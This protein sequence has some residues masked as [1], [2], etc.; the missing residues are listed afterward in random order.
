MRGT[1]IASP[2][3][4]HHRHRQLPAARLADRPREAAQLAPA[5]GP[6]GS[7]GASRSPTSPRPRTTRPRSRSPTR[8][9]PAS[10]RHR[11][12]DPAREL[13]QP[14]R[15]RARG[16]RHRQ[17]GAGPRPRGR[18][19]RVP[20]IVGKVRRTRPVEVDD[21]ASC[22]P[23]RPHRQDHPARPVH[24]EPAGPTSPTTTR[25][26]WRWTSRSPSTRRSATCSRR[27]PTRPDRRAVA[28]VAGRTR[29]RVR[30]PRH[31]PRAR[32]RTGTTAL[33][34]CFGYA[35]VVPTGRPATRSWPSSPT[36][37]PTCSRSR[38][39]SRSSTAVLERIA[40]KTVIVGVL[41]LQR[42]GRDARAGR[43]TASRRRSPC[44]RGRLQ[45]APT[46]G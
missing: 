37:P 5:A 20:R 41:D 39:P 36:A 22:A 45:S 29:P 42:G 26:S 4:A 31:R 19:E 11:R 27:A 38:P 15:D 7:C 14:L 43:R 18:D 23:H 30:A 17:P 13:L 33:H 1:L 9:A 16:L 12:R 6:R 25:P 28:A 21:L 2:A 35:H 46:A 10:T 34:T 44:P 3:D 24:D 32:G 40:D 8:S